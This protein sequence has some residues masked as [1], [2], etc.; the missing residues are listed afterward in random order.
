MLACG[1]LVIS[2]LIRGDQVLRVASDNQ[3]SEQDLDAF[4]ADVVESAVTI[5]SATGGA[6]CAS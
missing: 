6:N 1:E 3:L 2:S 5:A 4:L